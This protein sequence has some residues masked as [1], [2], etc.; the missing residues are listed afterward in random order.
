MHGRMKNARRVV[1]RVALVLAVLSVTLVVSLASAY[2]WLTTDSGRAWLARRIEDVYA[3]QVTGTLEIGQIRR[4]RGFAVDAE[5]LRFLDPRANEIIVIRSAH[6]EIEVS[7][8]LSKKLRFSN[9]HARDAR[10]IIAPGRTYSTSLEDAFG[11]RGTHDDPLDIDTGV[12]TIERT[13][14]V[15]AMGG[16]RVRLGGLNGSLRVYR[17]GDDPVNVDLNGFSGSL[18]LPGIEVLDARRFTAHG[19]V[20]AERSPVLDLRVRACLRRG[21]IPMRI[22][23][24][25]GRLRLRF[26]PSENRLAGMVLGATGLSSTIETERGAVN[27]RGVR[28]CA[29]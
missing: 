13:V 12:I 25:P 9:G 28:R 8:L 29:T 23:F 27:V 11:S 19:V 20:H 14:L 5:N 21:E 6:L 16:P 18:S 4:L 22:R 2:L 26:D 3:D 15:I 7:E 24:S 17:A 1:R 10:V